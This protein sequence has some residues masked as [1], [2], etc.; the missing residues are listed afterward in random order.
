MAKTIIVSFFLLLGLSAGASEIP[1]EAVSKAIQLK[2]EKFQLSNGLTVLLHEDSSAPMITYHQWFRVGSRH[3][4][5][6]RTGLAHFFEHLMFKGTEKYPA[7]V[8]DRIIQANGGNNNAFTSKDYTGYYT[9][10]PSDKLE[11]IMDIEA[12]RMRKL[13]FNQ[14]E[15]DS[16]RE[17]VKEERRLRTENDISGVI[18]EAMYKLVYKVH[19]YRWP[20]I[21]YM[22][23]L[24]A[25][26]MDEL[27]EF[28]RIHYAPNNAVVVI[29]G[30][31]KIG[32]TKSLIEKYYNSIASQP[33]PE[34]VLPQEPEQ[35]SQREQALQKDVQAPTV[36][37]AYR[38]S[39]AGQAD[40]YALDMISNLLSAGSSS[41]LHKRLVFQEQVVTGVSSWAYTPKEPGIFE[42]VAS[43]KPG[44]GADQVINSIQAEVA[45]LRNK[46]VDEKELNKIKN[47]MM[48]D[49]VQSL[50]TMQGKARALAVNEIL[51]GDYQE[52][53]RDL[54]KYFQVTPET[55]KA[56]AE[57]YLRAEKRSIIRVLP[58]AVE[59]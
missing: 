55:I 6:G 4:N 41:R 21:G 23:D 22:A 5:V 26:S 56:V 51:F 52:L 19:P 37:L 20:V 29:V 44:V 28:Y 9:N 1:I 33:L 31:I 57:K 54:G 17:V 2:V 58:K 27:K 40:S 14:K 45:K 30:D 11:L 24:N 15:I 25:T 39:A 53:F 3:E 42:I 16:E 49:Y 32:K 46:L 34:K 18:E 36:A 8:F 47:Q 35:T 48:T 59:S 7:R 10:I 38:I 13:V 50:K 43:V 12:D